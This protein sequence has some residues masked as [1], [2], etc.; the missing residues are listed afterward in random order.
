MNQLGFFDFNIR[1]GRMNKDIDPLFQLDKAIDWEVFRPTLEKA[2]QES[3]KSTAGA[4]GFDVIM[5]CKILVLQS[6]YTLSNDGMENQIL[7][8]YSLSRFLGLHD[9]RKIPDATIIWRFREDLTK[10]GEVAEL[11][12]TFANFL[13]ER[14]L[15]ARK[16][17]IADAS[18]ARVPVQA[19]SHDE[20]QQIKDGK[21]PEGWNENKQRQKDRDARWTRKT[22]RAITAI[23]PWRY[24]TS[25]SVHRLCPAPMCMTPMSLRH[26]SIRTIAARTFMRILPVVRSKLLRA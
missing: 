13:C 10:A 26:C 5:L 15:Q 6:L 24:S 21:R 4:K 9:A 12:T 14:G 23:S 20:S 16:G 2:R 22:R 3:R 25:L 11:F 1:L 7:D 17:Q 19:N 8:R 18:V